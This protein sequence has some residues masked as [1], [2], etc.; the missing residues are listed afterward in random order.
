MIDLDTATATDALAAL[1]DGSLSSQELL[2]AHLARIER[3]NRAVNAVVALDVERAQARAE[4]ADQARAAGQVWGPLHG[5]PL[6]IKDAFET[7]GLV[8][9]SGAPELA[10]HVPTTDAD[11]V[12]RLKAAGAI[13]FAKT[14]LPLYAG[15]MQTYN[16]VYGRTNNPWNLDRWSG[17]SSGGAAV[18]LATGMTLLELGSDIGGSIRSPSHFCGVYG[19]KPTWGVV[20]QRGHIPPAPG[21]LTPT[22]LNVVGPMGRSV[23]DLEL[24]LDVLAEAELPAVRPGLRTVADLRVGVW[25]EDEAVPLDRGVRDRLEATALALEAAGATLV[26]DARPAL[27]LEEQHLVYLNLLAAAIAPSY[28]DDVLEFTRQLA[29]A[30][31]PEDRGRPAAML[32]GMSESHLAWQQVDEQRHRIGAQ[33][34]T[35]FEQVD[36]MLTPVAP[37]AAQPHDT[38]TTLDQR[39]IQINGQAHPYLTMLVWSGLATLPGLPVTA[40]P[41]GLTAEGLPV[42]VQL[43]G[44]RRGDRTTLAVGAWTEAL[45]G[46]F[47]APPPTPRS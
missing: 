22:D 23:A 30:L 16:E 38:E 32:R 27:S 5:L 40:V 33:W 4:A 25:L 34:A 2:E 21:M 15:D 36:V 8:T 11:S 18:A 31:D 42:G 9:T 28:P 45:M 13:V 17:G 19:H 39:L 20:P 12:A 41:V 14:N 35:V 1:A 3:D 7:E 26:D 24:G 46:G 44:P 6:T 43:M 29:D 37:V 10:D 47:Q